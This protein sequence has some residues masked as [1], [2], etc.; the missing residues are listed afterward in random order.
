[1]KLTAARS[2]NLT[3][4]VSLNPTITGTADTPQTQKPH[5]IRVMMS[6]V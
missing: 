2:S 3:D 1:L 5:T 4:G 6:R